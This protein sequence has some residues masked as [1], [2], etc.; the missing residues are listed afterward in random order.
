MSINLNT[1]V[2]YSNTLLNID[3][4]DDYCPNGLQVEGKTEI[5]KIVTGVTACQAFIDAAIAADADLLL[6]HHG[7]FW[8]S[9]QPQLTGMKGKRIKT[10]HQHNLNLLS[11]HLPLD[12]HLE[13]GNNKQLAEKLG[14]NIKGCLDTGKPSNLLWQGE[15]PHA[16]SGTEFSTHITKVLGRAPLHI[17]GTTKTI[18]TVGW[19][20]GAAQNYLNYAVEAGLD[21]YITGEIS[22]STVHLAREMGIHF[23]SC[24]H[25]A[26]ERYGIQALGAHLAK[27]FNITHE[28]IDID[29]P[30]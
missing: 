23:F 13:L 14:I 27:Q 24:G 16:L 2:N 10:L 1:L 29:N 9:E 12:V 18:K 30:V 8:K 22:E 7:F 19:C 11:Y 28:F 26:T 4:I 21:A 17:A 6:V 15:L 5:I 3:T 20:T 25:H